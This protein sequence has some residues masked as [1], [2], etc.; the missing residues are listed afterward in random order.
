VRRGV[1][2]T[3]QQSGVSRD[4]ETVVANGLPGGAARIDYNRIALVRLGQLARES[5]VDQQVNRMATLCCL[6]YSDHWDTYWKNN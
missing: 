1:S 2:P 6:T 5:Q 4:Q 3:C